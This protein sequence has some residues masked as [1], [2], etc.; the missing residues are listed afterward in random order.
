[1]KERLDETLNYYSKM[2][3]RFARF[4]ICTMGDVVEAAN[5]CNTVPLRGGNATRQAVFYVFGV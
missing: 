1:M 2:T 5:S 3:T 4:S